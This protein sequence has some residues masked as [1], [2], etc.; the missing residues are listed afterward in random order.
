NE[1]C[2]P[3]LPHPGNNIKECEGEVH[4]FLLL[5]QLICNEYYEC[6]AKAIT[7]IIKTRG[8]ERETI[9]QD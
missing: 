9:I 6:I 8:K 3:L 7:I 1:E 5:L 4:V 2:I